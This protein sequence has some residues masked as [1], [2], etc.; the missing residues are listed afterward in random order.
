MAGSLRFIIIATLPSAV[1][2]IVI[3]R[4][5]ISLLERGAFDSSASALVYSTLQFFA[6]GI[7]VHSLLEIIARSFYADK[8]TLTPLWAAIGGA[9]ITFVVSYYGSNVSF[10]ESMG[11]HN[12]VARQFPYLGIQPVTGNV[13]A[14]ALANTLG[15]TFEVV[16]LMWILR[17]RWNGLNENSLAMTTAK[18]LAASLAMALVVVIIEAVWRMIGFSERGTMFTV[19]QLGIQTLVGAGVFIGVALRLRMDELKTLIAIVLRRQ[20]MP[21]TTAA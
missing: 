1:G 16:L 4:P 15:V 13:G 11:L 21:E 17:R 12:A 3:G 18:T 10:V 8:D 14:L 2:L 6:L 7:I 5:L 9:I 19:L 20:S